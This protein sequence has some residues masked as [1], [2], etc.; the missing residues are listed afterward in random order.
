MKSDLSEATFVVEGVVFTIQKNILAAQS[1]YFHAMLYGGFAETTQKEIYL[2]IPISAFKA[3]LEF[4][5]TGRMSLAKMK[6]KDVLD[7]LSMTHEYGLEKL[8]MCICNYLLVALSL[9]NCCVILDTAKLY[10]FEELYDAC[11]TFI[12]QNATK[13]LAK[14]TFKTLSKDSL[15]SILQRDS[16]FA[17]EIDIF[18]A[19]NGWCQN[20][21]SADIQLNERQFCFKS[22]FCS[23]EENIVNL[24][25]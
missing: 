13:V 21:P 4:V 20:N 6:L 25:E 22:L 17:P 19:V 7:I 18:K 8:T 23:I 24:S 11:L 1:S 16:F 15:C 9:E 5:Y 3:L 12:D 10:S 2:N 14:S